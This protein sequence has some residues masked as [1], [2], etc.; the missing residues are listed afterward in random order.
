MS[1]GGFESGNG[2]F[3][4]VIFECCGVRSVG[5]IVCCSGT[6]CTWTMG[7]TCVL[8]VLCV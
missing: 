6:T 7:V 1:I 4:G 5:D 8:G 3:I 2:V